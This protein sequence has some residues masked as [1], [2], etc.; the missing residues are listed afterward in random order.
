[1]TNALGCFAM[2][3]ATTKKADQKGRVMLPNDFAGHLVIVERVS[4]DEVRVRKAKAVPTRPT[5]DEFLAGVTPQ[6]THA[7]TDFGPPVGQELL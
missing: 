1:V 6:N 2:A 7:E 5:L 3:E 4:A